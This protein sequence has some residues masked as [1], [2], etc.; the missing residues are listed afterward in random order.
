MLLETLILTLCQVQFATYSLTTNTTNRILPTFPNVWMSE[1]SIVS[2]TLMRRVLGFEI[3]VICAGLLF[4]LLVI[5]CY[6][7]KPEF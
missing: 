2:G 4:L 5:S 7:R 1:G 3:L 6:R